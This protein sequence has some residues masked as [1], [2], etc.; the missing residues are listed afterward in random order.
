MTYLVELRK[1][2][3]NVGGK[4]EDLIHLQGRRWLVVPKTMV[5]VWD[6]YSDSIRDEPGTMVKVRADVARSIVPGKRY[7]VRSSAN[8]EDSEQHSYAGRF[9][10][11]LNVQGVDGICAAI[12]DVW[13]STRD[14]SVLTYLRKTGASE[15]SL[16]MAVLIQEMV[17]TIISGVSFSR[18]PITGASEVIL[19]AVEGSGERLVQEGVTPDRWVFHGESVERSGNGTQMSESL[20]MRV[21]TLTRR[22]DETLG[23]PLDLEW[24]YDGEEVQWVQAREITAL[25]DLNIY[26]DSFSKEFLPGMIKPLVW[27]INTPLVNGAWARLFGKLTGMRD[28]DPSTF[29]KQFYYRAYFNMSVV[30]RVWERMGMPRD[31]LE[32]LMVVGGE[33]PK[34]TFRPTPKMMLTMPRV[35]LFLI[36]MVRLHWDLD[37]LLQSVPEDLK[38]FEGLDLRSMDGEALLIEV[39]RLFHVDQDLA[40]FN[41]LTYLQLAI[42]NRMLRSALSK[43][44]YELGDVRLVLERNGDVVRYPDQ[45]LER[46]VM[47]YQDLP[48]E[49]RAKVDRSSYDGL[50]DVAGAEQLTQGLEGFLS[51]FGYLSDSGNDIS[52]RPWREDPDTILRTVIGSGAHL[53]SRAQKEISQLDLPWNMRFRIRSI[54]GRTCQDAYFKE[55]VGELYGQGYSLLRPLFLSIGD[56]LVEKNVIRSREDIFYLYLHEV[57]QT[58]EGGCADNTCNDLRIRVSMR[59][60][61]ME[62]LRDAVLPSIIY[63]ERAPPMERVGS[64]LMKGVATSGGYHQG[65]ARVVKGLSDLSKVEPGDVL[66]IPYSDVGWTPLFA[67]AGAV[68]SEAGGMLSHSS[69]IAREYG[70]PAVV[71]VLGATSI[72]DGTQLLVDGYKGE[73]RRIL[74]AP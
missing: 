5:L 34:G 55:K 20:A 6:A 56:Q 54:Y 30:G 11:V 64:N 31:S 22:L 47:T 51:Q 4:G 3:K 49:V 72:E 36:D 62:G 29:S 24:V 38:H 10:S 44:G 48:P 57:R 41:I 28:L 35:A 37:R 18:N 13:S 46:L 19:E 33:R 70:I 40:Y 25:R 69:I 1:G 67:K 63:G 12:L 66:V 15:G 21:A 32:R 2:V 43:A 9:R 71:S 52:V 27:T 26:S 7:A 65:P 39:D 60:K 59:R 73:V 58:V 16:K 74:D 45:A 14:P 17:P 68:V 8:L 23:H 50:R 61:E 42:S 53:R